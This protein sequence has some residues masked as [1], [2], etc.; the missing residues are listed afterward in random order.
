MNA[1]IIFSAEHLYLLSIAIFVIYG[2]VTKARKRFWLL[3]VIV[4]PVSFL[5]SRL[6]GAFFYDP[7]PFVDPSVIPL[8]P[9]AADNGFPSDHALL[10]G[11]L[12]AVVSVFS[13]PVA[14]ALWVLA[15]IVGGARVLARVHHLV[16]ILGS[17]AIALIA[18]FS[19]QGFLKSRSFARSRLAARL[20]L[21]EIQRH[22]EGDAGKDGDR[23]SDT[24]GDR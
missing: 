15:L 11:T 21:G 14:V 19:A 17:Y 1:L 22:E 5:L 4:L 3:A 2:V 13:A 24:E 18:L 9:H 23:P 16:D 12:A 7:R 8:F 20:G 10:T 6:A